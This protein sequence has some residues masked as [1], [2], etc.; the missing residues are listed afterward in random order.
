MNLQNLFINK[1][2][3]KN[4]I[5]CK[6]H[7]KNKLSITKNIMMSIPRASRALRSFNL[8]TRMNKLE[9]KFLKVLNPFKKEMFR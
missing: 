6:I 4:L 3:L 1:I 9:A 5:L 8:K 7:K 2:K